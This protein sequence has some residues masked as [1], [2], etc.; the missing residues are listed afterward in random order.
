MADLLAAL[1]GEAFS[2]NLCLTDTEAALALDYIGSRD[3]RQETRVEL[4]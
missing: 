2:C 3:L 1:K 4:C